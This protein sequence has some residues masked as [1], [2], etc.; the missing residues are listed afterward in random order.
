MSVQLSSIK[1]QSVSSRAFQ[2]GSDAQGCFCQASRLLLKLIP[3]LQD[4]AFEMHVL[5][6]RQL[7]RV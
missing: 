1:L 4:F 5:S 7:L 6:I 3:V 2:I